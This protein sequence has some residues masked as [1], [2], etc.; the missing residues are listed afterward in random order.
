MR[1]AKMM[2]MKKPK[3]NR[4]TIIKRMR[5]PM[6]KRIKNRRR[7]TVRMLV[8]ARIKVRSLTKAVPA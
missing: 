2:R 6:K 3:P 8:T 4:R 1:K 7:R 5:R